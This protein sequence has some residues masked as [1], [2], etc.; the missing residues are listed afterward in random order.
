METKMAKDLT[1]GIEKH[2][3]GEHYE[4]PDAPPFGKDEELKFVNQIK[5]AR[6]KIIAFL[7]FSDG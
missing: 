6:D 5:E 2:L 4:M 1:A 7:P 3:V